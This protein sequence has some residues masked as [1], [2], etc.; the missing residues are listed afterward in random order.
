MS[1]SLTLED[2][3]AILKTSSA[4]LGPV[5]DVATLDACS[6]CSVRY[7]SR[8]CKL[9]AAAAAELGGKS[10]ACCRDDIMAFCRDNATFCRDR[11]RSLSLSVPSALCIVNGRDTCAGMSR[12]PHANRANNTD[13]CTRCDAQLFSF[14]GQHLATCLPKP[15]ARPGDRCCHLPAPVSLPLIRGRWKLQSKRVR[16][17]NVANIAV[18]YYRLSQTDCYYTLTC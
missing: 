17:L 9:R 8:A 16:V 2:V 12:L 11:C 1:F 10:A 13:L 7:D 4:E 6:L 3:V 15:P 14:C 5:L 18:N